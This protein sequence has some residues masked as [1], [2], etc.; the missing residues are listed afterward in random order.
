MVSKAPVCGFRL[1]VPGGS[2]AV[3][4]RRLESPPEAVWASQPDAPFYHRSTLRSVGP[5]SIHANCGLAGGDVKFIVLSNRAQERHTPRTK[6]PSSCKT[7][8]HTSL[9]PHLYIRHLTS[10]TCLWSLQRHSRHYGF[11]LRSAKPPSCIRSPCATRLQQHPPAPSWCRQLKNSNACSS[12]PQTHQS[13][14]PTKS[15]RIKDQLRFF[16]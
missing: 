4:W 10:T 5:I 9:S 14:N 8:R 11:C 2:D 13:I 15:C 1:F 16:L 6:I 7:S 12:C 3:H